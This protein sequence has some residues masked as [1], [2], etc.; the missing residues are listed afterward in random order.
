MLTRSGLA[1]VCCASALVAGS[2]ARAQQAN[3]SDSRSELTRLLT[4]RRDTL[5]M[6]VEL[7]EQRLAQSDAMIDSVVTARNQLLDA[8]LQLAT[9]KNQRLDIL[10]KRIENMRGL[11][12]ATKQRHEDGK[13]TMVSV[14]AVT[15]GR[16]QAEIDLAREKQ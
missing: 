1:I 4:K 5:Q 6:R 10:R 7:L 15:A 11:E 16:L 9:T 8:N 12:D 2:A 13:T 14:L 3:E